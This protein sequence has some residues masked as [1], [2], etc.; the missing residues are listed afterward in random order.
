MEHIAREQIERAI[1]IKNQAAKMNA[2]RQL[3]EIRKRSPYSDKITPHIRS[4]QE[5]DLYGSL[6]LRESCI[7]RP[8][9]VQDVDFDLWVPSE[10][11]TNQDLMK[12]GLAPYKHSGADGKVE[13]HHVGQDYDG[14][15]VEL[16]AG[17]HDA[18]NKLLH[19]SHKESWRNDPELEAAFEKERAQYWM[20]RAEGRYEI[21]SHSFEN[22]VSPELSA[23]YEYSL[24][25]RDACEELFS[26]CTVEDL[27]YLSDVAKSFSM[28][29]QVGAATFDE[30][31]QKNRDAKPL[32]PRCGSTDCVMNGSYHARKESVQRYLCNR[33]GKTF[34][35][36]SDSLVCSTSMSLRQWIKF[37]DCLYHGYSTKGLAKAC[38]ISERTAHDARIRVFYALKQLE[39][40]VQLQGNVA[41][42]ETYLLVSYKGNHSNQDD[43]VMPR[44]VHRRGGENHQKGISKNHACVMCAVDE[45]GN[46]VAKVAGYGY[47]SAVKL[48]Y[49]LEPHL[50]DQVCCLYSDKSGA[51]KS[52]ADSCRLAIKQEKL[53][54]KGTRK[55]TNVSF[56]KDTLKVNRYIQIA[57]SYHS[58]LK[59]FLSRFSGIS[60]KLLSGYLCL[61]AWRERNKER[62][63]AEVY[64]EL[65]KVMVEPGQHLTVEEIVTGGRLPNADGIERRCKGAFKDE[66]RAMRIF[67]RYAKGDPVSA[68][69]ADERCAEKTIRNIVAKVRKSGKGYKT[70]K[71][72]MREQK[73]KQAKG[74]IPESSLRLMDRDLE[75]FAAREQWHGPVPQFF[76]EM[77]EKYHVS[78]SSIHAAILRV[79]RMEHLKEDIFIHE[80]VSYPMQ[81]EIYRSVY[82]DYLRLREQEP[83]L[84]KTACQERLAAQYHYSNQNISRILILMEGENAADS[85]ERTHRVARNEAYKRDKAMFVDFMRWMGTRQDFCAYAAE[86]YGVSKAT[87]GMTL[88]NCLF[89]A[90]ERYEQV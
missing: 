54:R 6:C 2:Q 24:V 51:I 34:N 73:A 74:P 90:P 45:Y 28:M 59:K 62:D 71:E 27:D 13:L 11:C 84:S 20:A 41:L 78:E 9:L 79:N 68:I 86:K 8:C 67:D 4:Y 7:T 18:N 81:A 31:V 36:T 15:F 50:G 69:A 25:L 47:P 76:R 26:G 33:C 60:T 40:Q 80:N 5:L 88:R 14:P 61:F 48:K 77:A 42:D 70:Q 16:T 46:S 12:K 64:Q 43:F 35:Q 23:R 22:F 72:L 19:P 29:R 65:L 75:I 89:A 57:N 21:S 55:A 87:V 32:C 53:L 44:E 38:G 3:S 49:V 1:E 37:I 85:G 17:E 63:M 39:D 82:A 52:F 30:F 56:G 10:N 66:A 58:R 83:A